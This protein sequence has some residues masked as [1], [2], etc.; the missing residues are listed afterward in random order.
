MDK[1]TSYV[2]EVYPNIKSNYIKLNCNEYY[3]IGFYVTGSVSWNINILNSTFHEWCLGSP[4]D[5]KN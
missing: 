1:N 5:D 3:V 2:V 4:C